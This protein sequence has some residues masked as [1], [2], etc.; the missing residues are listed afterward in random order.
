MLKFPFG[1][2]LLRLFCLLAFAL[3]FSSLAHAQAPP[4]T[5]ITLTYL[6]TQRE[7]ATQ[8]FRVTLNQ[9]ATQRLTFTFFTSPGANP[10][11]GSAAPQTG[12][13]ELPSGP[14]QADY[15][16]FIREFSFEVGRS[17]VDVSVPT[18]QDGNY[19]FDENFSASINDFRYNGQFAN[20][21]VPGATRV[22]ATIVNDD[23]PPTIT[24]IQPEAILEGD[25]NNLQTQNYN[26]TVDLSLISERQIDL[27]FTT[28]DVTATSAGTTPGTPG[29]LPG[30]TDFS[31]KSSDPV[32]VPAGTKQFQYTVLVFG[33]DINEGDE[34]FLLRAE[35][36][37]QLAGTA[38]ST[39]TGTIRENDLPSYNI[40]ASR[41]TAEEGL[42][43]E[44]T[45]NLVDR[46]GLESFARQDIT[47][48]YS[49]QAITATGPGATP[50]D[51][52]DYADPQGG[53]FT[54]LRGQSRFRLV[55][56]TID[57]N[58]IE[59][60]ET[61]RLI[62]TNAPG[63]LAPAGIGSTA[64]G[65]INDTGDNNSGTVFTIQDRSVIEG[66]GGLNNLRFTVNLTNATNQQSSVDYQTAP[67]TDGDVA[68][69]ATAG[70]DY[71]STTGRL[72]F[73][74]NQ[75]QAFFDV[76]VTT[77]TINELDE[78][79]LVRLFNPAN[80]KFDN[81]ATEVIRRGT[82]IDDDPAGVLSVERQQVDVDENVVGGVVNI[83]VNFAPTGPQIRP[84]IVDFT[85]LSETAVESGNRDYFGKAGTLTFNPGEL[86]K[87]IPIEIIDDKVREND[88]TFTV[89]LSNP[90][91]ATL[92]LQSATQVTIKD[93][94]PLP[95]VRISPANGAYVEGAGD[96][97]LNISLLTPSQDDVS[98]AYSF[99]D[100][101]ATNN[102]DYEGV[103]GTVTFVAGGPQTL[104]APFKINDDGTAEGNET[105][106]VV[107]APEVTTPVTAPNFNI[108][109][110]VNT[111]R[112]TI[113]DNDRTPDLRI[114]DAS[115]VEGNTGTLATGAELV[116]PITLNRP[117]S[118]PVSFSY[119]T[120]NL[121]QP[122]CTP[123]NGCEKASDSDYQVAR[124]VVVTLAPGT[125]VG[126][127]RIRVTP[128]TLNEFNDQFAIVT[129]NLTNA[130]PLVYADPVSQRQRFGT[131]A[132]G[133]ITNDD[134][135]GTITLGNPTTP[136]TGTAI[137]AGI[138][139]GYNRGGA[140]RVGEAA[141]FLVTLP[142]PAGRTVT[143]NYRIAGV[144]NNADVEDLTTGPGRG[145]I[146]FFSGDTTRNISLRA[147]PD[148]LVEGSER[149]DVILSIADTNGANGY[150]TTGAISSTTILDRTP[151]VD[152]VSPTIGFSAYGTVPASRV[153]ISGLQLRT[154]GN[155]RVD[156]VLFNG[157]A[158]N[159]G[160]IQYLSDNAIA[161]SVPENAKT[162]PL[163]LRLV[164]GTLL[165]NAGLS[166]TV[167][168]QPLPDF[169]V[170][171]VIESFTPTTGVAGASTVTITGR[172]FKDPTNAVTGV[173]F[174]GGSVLVGPNLTVDSD[175]RI[176]V[177]VP[178]GATNGPLR[179]ASVR[180]G[181]GPASQLSFSVVGAAAGGLRFGDNL[182]RNAILEGSIGNIN[183]PV[184][185]FNG[186]GDNTF[187]RPYQVF[188]VPATQTTGANTGAPLP[189][190]PITVRFQVTAST[191]AVAGANPTRIPRIAVQTD[192]T[193]VG[194]PTFLNSRSDDNGIIDLAL[195][196]RFN[197]ASPITV[198]I[199][200]SGTDNDPPI[201]GGTPPNVTVT[202]RVIRSDN[203]TFFPVTPN[204]RE[205]SIRVDRVE[206]V[207]GNNQT[208][209]AFG[210]GS[211]ASFSIPYSSAATSNSI[212]ISEAFNVPT[213][214][215][216]SIYRY[217][218]AGQ[219]NKFGTA[220]ANNADFVEVPN[221]ARLERGVGYRLVVGNQTIQLK[222]KGV[223]VFTN[224]N[225]FTYTLSRNLNLSAT[226]TNQ[227]NATNGYNFIGFP[228]N[229][230]QY[231]MVD[232]GQARVVVDGV[233]RSLADAASAGFINARLFVLNDQGNL[234]AADSTIIRPF[235]AYFVQVF[236]DNVTLRLINPTR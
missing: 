157:V 205:L 51:S 92:G 84:V 113:I 91:G 214:A 182:D 187:H 94:E 128:D 39:A 54:I 108:E 15:N 46:A 110:G 138:A 168:V 231:Q 218:V 109:N 186:T 83:V 155:P 165:S 201:I 141:N 211:R 203:P 87:T 67:L 85:T 96:Q 130:V 75:T 212:P 32:S 125:T 50:P 49:L 129:R 25:S 37:P 146:T 9:P 43:I 139:E 140:I 44:F 66:T 55:I 145:S 74:P 150:N 172:N 119:S 191:P 178:N 144:A 222:T 18:N 170:Q 230:D 78:V 4:S 223:G 36:S 95:L 132:F 34:T 70:V 6:G 232:F 176:N 3:S 52:P 207:N 148:N 199:V 89:R 133:T 69:R 112:F 102:S 234:V 156:A 5:T 103:D 189:I 82:I 171:P 12:A 161:V 137:T 71:T 136:S 30:Q 42:P 195:D 26:F 162:G 158:V 227:T 88:E 220:E 192:L 153:T 65:T 123:A 2:A 10:P 8:D 14:F 180:G 193:N 58:I 135:G 179:I 142:T 101:T 118:R 45:F 117:S 81:N 181:S 134:A 59:Q 98:V 53:S 127:I 166:T 124:N 35:Y 213:G 169:V 20:N 210:P 204:N 21:I 27:A 235:Q 174:V 200:D 228:F 76:P 121:T 31:R 236:R 33:D 164:D 215:T 115:V 19:E 106:S 68:T 160:G 105:F 63:T 17:T 61:F 184:R 196:E 177:V 104:P 208:A 48:T 47:F 86:T 13:R 147:T 77:D 163:R 188:V 7:G 1:S 40:D 122:E 116:F 149:L 154:E 167:P 225:N 233:E 159:R 197:P 226:G 72:V 120:L 73:A 217:N 111:A 38:S 143:V 79:F 28:T 16:R 151:R 126:E 97:R 100:G 24:I 202:A 114:G 194:R 99:V 22:T 41:A 93:D 62:V 221:N 29:F 173:L 60:T 224:V 107:I 190:T 80:A 185:N 64:I 152:T 206:P 56:P 57:D 11:F 183:Q 131:T 175:T 216:Y 198:S 229:P 90:N 219:T 209:I 23:P